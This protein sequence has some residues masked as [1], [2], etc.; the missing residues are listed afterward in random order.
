MLI[1]T[2]LSSVNMESLAR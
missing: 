1:D 2:M